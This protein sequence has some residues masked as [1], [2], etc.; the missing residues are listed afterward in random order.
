[1]GSGKPGKHLRM[2]IN[3]RDTEFE[4]KEVLGDITAEIVISSLDISRLTKGA[5]RAKRKYSSVGLVSFLTSR[6]EMSARRWRERQRVAIGFRPRFDRQHTDV[7][8]SR[9][10][11]TAEA[12]TPGQ[13]G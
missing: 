13:V 3:A 12:Q 7:H 10:S 6:A 11:Q 5:V 2:D 4:D 8:P 9:A 1:M